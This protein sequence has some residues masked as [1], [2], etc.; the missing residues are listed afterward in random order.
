MQHV[1]I[2]ASHADFEHEMLLH[3]VEDEAWEGMNEAAA[4]LRSLGVEPILSTAI[5]RTIEVAHGTLKA[6]D[7]LPDSAFPA[8]SRVLTEDKP[9]ASGALRGAAV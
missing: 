9:E 6:S 2:T 4:T 7:A 8:L 5:A 1:G 3:A